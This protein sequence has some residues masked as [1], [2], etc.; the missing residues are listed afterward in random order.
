MSTFREFLVEN[1][2]P[3]SF[4][5]FDHLKGIAQNGPV[6]GQPALQPKDIGDAINDTVSAALS[7][8]GMS[9]TAENL[10]DHV[11]SAVEEVQDIIDGQI[12]KAKF[13]VAA[14]EVKKKMDSVKRKKGKKVSALKKLIKALEKLDNVVE[15][16]KNNPA[17]KDI[18]KTILGD[19]ENTKHIIVTGLNA[20]NE[21]K[22]SES[23]SSWLIKFFK[24]LWGGVKVI[25]KF[26]RSNIKIIAA[27]IMIVWIVY[28]S[29]TEGSVTGGLQSVSRQITTVA[30][31]AWQACKGIFESGFQWVMDYPV[32]FI[33]SAF[34]KTDKLSAAYE[35]LA[36]VAATKRRYEVGVGAA[37][38]FGVI[39]TYIG[40]SWLGTALA[41]AA[42]SAFGLTPVGAGV[43]VL[44]AAAGVTGGLA[45]SYSDTM[46]T[47]YRQDLLY[48]QQQMHFGYLVQAVKGI[49]A[50]LVSTGALRIAYRKLIRKYNVK[51]EDAQKYLSVAKTAATVAVDT[52]RSNIKFKRK[53]NRIIMKSQQK[54]VGMGTRLVGFDSFA[55]AVDHNANESCLRLD[56]NFMKWREKYLTTGEDF[57]GEF[58]LKKLKVEEQEAKL[59]QKKSMTK[60][61]V[62]EQL[63]KL[64]TKIDSGLELT[65]ENLNAFLEDMNEE[66]NNESRENLYADEESDEELSDA[67]TEEMPPLTALV[68]YTSIRLRF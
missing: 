61:Y 4:K 23:W 6:P 5:T 65:T 57:E 16:E 66:V 48:E 58:Q 44:S 35:E 22:T 9:E 31:T 29:F 28:T 36:R 42:M 41:S 46:D 34:G 27:A 37:G 30:T 20:L 53:L 17:Q 59:E 13:V 68:S 62:K 54:V 67:P 12:K 51:E 63:M 3:Y 15:H 56:S 21:K 47:R 14:A 45:D 8:V 43:M 24:K 26:I 7:S 60:S 1:N 18:G 38:S 11:D 2:I 33:Q 10:R 55:D 19:E 32:W 25:W 39:A 64:K 50:V 49:L 40:G 52:Y